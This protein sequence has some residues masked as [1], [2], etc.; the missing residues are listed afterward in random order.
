MSVC[1]IPVF[2]SAGCIASN[3]KPR[4]K[5]R[6]LDLGRD[7]LAMKFLDRE[8]ELKR[9]DRLTGTGG[10][11]VIWGRRRIGKTRLLLEW[12]KRHGGLYTV[13]DQSAGA[14]QR[15]YFANALAAVF[16]GFDE[17]QYPDWRSLLER[18]SS[19]A[20]HHGWQGPLIMDEFPYLVVTS[21]ELPSAFQTWVDHK[22]KGARLTVVLAGSSQRMMQGL[23]MSPTESLYGRAKEAFQLRPLA[24][25]Y[26][27]KALGLT[28][29]REA[30]TAYAV[31][32]GVP[33]YWELMAGL[34]LPLDRAIDDLVL[35]PLGPLHEEP[36]R[37]LLEE[38]P[39][40]V[41]LRQVLDAIGLGAHRVSEI[42]ARI[43]T[44][45]TSLSR[46]LQRLMELGLVQRELPFGAPS[47]SARRSLYKIADPFCRF[48]FRVV[49]PRRG[50][51]AESPPKARQKLWVQARA[52]IVSAAWEDLCR[53]WVSAGFFQHEKANAE[54]DWEP[55][56]R[57]WHGNGPEW[58]VVSQSLDGQSVLLGEVKWSDRPFDLPELRSLAKSLV[59]KGLPPVKTLKGRNVFHVLFVPELT[60]GM[61]SEIDGVQLVTGQQVLQDM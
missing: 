4:H 51:L 28:S 33:R 17:V 52:G 16:P 36:D 26:L 21:P 2:A 38:S 3:E 59:M 42:A 9:L 29:V 48:W 11:G 56:R 31:W 25:G 34:G 14:I 30:I 37:L 6:A 41:A 1:I 47:A 23:V 40:A 44:P 13:A 7:E 19:E 46:P 49:A 32:G 53:Q 43:Q 54:R 27:P 60:K 5:G 18:V 57:F 39:P 35:N 50:F 61:P 22:A 20:L 24:P 15:R 45:A 8:E 58:D 55:A 12:C 10:L